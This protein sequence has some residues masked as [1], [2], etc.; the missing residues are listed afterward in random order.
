M[1][2]SKEYFVRINDLDLND[3]MNIEA[4][5]SFFQDA[6][7]LHAENLGIGYL[8][9][10]EKNCYWVLT[11]TRLT[12]IADPKA[13]D[14]IKVNTWPLEKGKVN[15]LRE[16]E[17]YDSNDDLIVKGESQWCLIDATTRKIVRADIIN[18]PGECLSKTVYEDKIL[19]IK[20]MKENL[21]LKH[22][23]MLSEIDHNMHMNNTKYGK[24]IYDC[25]TI[26]EV[27]NFKDCSLQYLHEARLDDIIDVYKIVTDKNIYITGA[28]LDTPCFTALVVI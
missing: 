28:V 23:V 9:L 15:F 14:Q 18:Y 11:K 21:V 5:L 12:K 7:S 24:L 3:H 27:K 16:Y 22:Q 4:I 13:Y 2:L 20:P 1:I 6:A 26:E 25:L 10:K 8:P 19:S 17:I